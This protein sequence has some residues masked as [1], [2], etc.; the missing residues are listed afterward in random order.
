MNIAGRYLPA[1]GFEGS[2]DIRSNENLQFCDLP[3]RLW[4]AVGVS[5]FRVFGL[6]FGFWDA[7]LYLLLGVLCHRT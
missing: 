4:R 2:Y 7:F 6:L 1:K 3:C 5:G